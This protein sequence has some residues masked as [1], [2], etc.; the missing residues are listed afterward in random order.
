M[1]TTNRRRVTAAA[2]V[3]LALAAGTVTVLTARTVDSHG[4][5]AS[6]GAGPAAPV[7]GEPGG[8]EPSGAEPPVIMPGRPGEPARTA[9][10]G[11]GKP[12]PDRYNSMDVWF[13]R[14]MVPHHT[15]ALQMAELAAQHASD[16]G[17]R[18]LADRVRASQVPE[19]QVLRGW[20]AA[21]RLGL[22]D[23]GA[24]H[25]HAAMPGMQSDA[26]MRRLSDARGADFDRLFVE[27][28]TA[29]HQGAIEMADD[30]LR[31]GVDT[32]IHQFAT[33]VAVEQGAEIDRMRG[34]G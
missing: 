34:L 25:D 1:A 5:S 12:D 28:M 33:S 2:V 18:A 6:D 27:M 3:F 11:Q 15:Q 17:V 20:L 29:H 16:T 24:G 7:S 31:V 13:V 30:L 21:R 9:P 19:I 22:D 8:G 23:P 10:A 26:A 14:M 32:T 4:T